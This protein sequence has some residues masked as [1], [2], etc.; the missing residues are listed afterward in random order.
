MSTV[1]EVLNYVDELAPFEL[2]M[3]WD[4]VGLLVGDKDAIVTGCV[5]ALDVNKDVLDFA[6]EQ[7]ANLIIT[8]HPVIFGGLKKLTTDNIIYKLVAK[9][10]S[11][12]SAHTNLD[13][14]EGGVN[15]A[16]AETLELENIRPLENTGGL[17]RVGELE[18]EMLPSEFVQF[19]KRVLFAESV[20]YTNFEKPI[21]T[22]ALVGGEGSDFAFACPEADAYLSGELKHHVFIDAQNMEKQIFA[23]G[24]HESEVCV[25]EPLTKQI[26]AKFTDFKAQKY[27][28]CSTCYM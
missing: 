21:K 12:I 26:N 7:K 8:H 15:D 5:L 11:V 22:V 25:L 16:L 19:V 9:N 10:I 23:V 27:L 2:A 20:N 24:H 28:L 17:G 1:L 6:I 4:N 3:K 18:K 13:L 14:V